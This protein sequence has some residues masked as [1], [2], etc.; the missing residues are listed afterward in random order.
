MTFGDRT[1]PYYAPE[2]MGL[3]LLGVAERDELY[4]FD[5]LAAWYHPETNR[6]YAAADAGC[7]CPIPFEDYPIIDT[8]TPINHESELNA[9]ASKQIPRDAVDKLKRKVRRKLAQIASQPK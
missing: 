3:E 2:K 1:N 7:S 5:M 8:L 9:L 6:V 4:A